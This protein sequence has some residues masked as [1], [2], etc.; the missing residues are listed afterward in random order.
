MD[1]AATGAVAPSPVPR[2]RAKVPRS[3]WALEKDRF[4]AWLVAWDGLTVIRGLTKSERGVYH[5]LWTLTGGQFRTPVPAS[6]GALLAHVSTRTW[7]RA[8]RRLVD[9]GLLEVRWSTGGA[10]SE[11]CEYIALCLGCG[12]KPPAVKRELQGHAEPLRYSPHAVLPEDVDAEPAPAEVLDV[13]D[14]EPA[15]VVMDVADAIEVPELPS[16]TTQRLV[17]AWAEQVGGIDLA[18][19]FVQELSPRDR[20]G[21]VATL[22][23]EE[24]PPLMVRPAADPARTARQMVTDYLRRW[25]IDRPPT[26][27]E[28][29]QA[30]A[31]VD[32]WGLAA[33]GR[34]LEAAARLQQYLAG[35][36]ERPR[37][38]GFLL[39]HFG[40][41]P[42]L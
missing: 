39:P 34:Y 11:A 12:Y 23:H 32:R 21:L 20:W 31:V 5:L 14:P 33:W 25:G 6:R 28:L 18:R 10:H 27:H 9:L 4:R 24:P 37:F 38:F 15:E 7:R 2:R 42:T 1:A 41:P 8:V 40:R 13:A 29:Q 16:E 35:R 30:R 36:D 26:R 19:A 17:E 3:P 22:L